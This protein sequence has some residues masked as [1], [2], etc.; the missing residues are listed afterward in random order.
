MD[1]DVAQVRWQ[2]DLSDLLRRYDI[3]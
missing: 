3:T 1:E 2:D